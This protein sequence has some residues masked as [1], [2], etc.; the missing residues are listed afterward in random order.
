MTTCRSIAVFTL[1]CVVAYGFWLS[2]Q[3]VNDSRGWTTREAALLGMGL[4]E[5]GLP[6][7]LAKIRYRQKFGLGH[8][9]SRYFVCD[10]DL[11][12]LKG[13]AEGQIQ[14]YADHLQSAVVIARDGSMDSVSELAP[15]WMR[16]EPYADCVIYHVKHG[17]PIIIVVDQ[18]NGLLYY[19]FDN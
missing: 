7:S 5:P 19:Y 15:E 17:S 8:G 1:I 4:D 14:T 11:D 12:E 18:S 9:Q 10:G 6:R 13:F 3:L 2:R 16:P